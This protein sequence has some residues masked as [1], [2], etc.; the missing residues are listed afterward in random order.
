MVRVLVHAVLAEIHCVLGSVAQP[1]F[2]A[3]TVAGPGEKFVVPDGADISDQSGSPAPIGAALVPVEM[4][5][6][7]GSA[8]VCVRV[9]LLVAVGVGVTI[10]V[11]VAVTVVGGARSAIIRLWISPA[12]TSCTEDNGVLQ[13]GPA[14]TAT[15]VVLSV[16]VQ[17]PR[18]PRG[19]AP[20]ATSV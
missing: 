20:H 17:S 15:G 13:D 4:M 16:V 1:P 11:A 2:G 3:M 18:L 10:R 7:I 5:T 8:H 6:E 19:F 14:S 12:S 9:G